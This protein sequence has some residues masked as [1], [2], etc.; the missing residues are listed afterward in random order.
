MSEGYFRFLCPVCKEFQT[1][2]N[3]KTNLARCFRCEKNFNSIDL[4][5][6]VKGVGFVE[7]VQY[8][9]ELLPDI[10]PEPVDQSQRLNEMLSGVGKFLV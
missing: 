10:P 9:Q 1:A 3:P 5:M 8:L 7:S 2:V 6:R 4:V